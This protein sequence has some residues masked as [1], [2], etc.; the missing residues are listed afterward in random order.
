MNGGVC[1][2]GRADPWLP[3]MD[4]C[5]IPCGPIIWICGADSDVDGGA[6]AGSGRP[7]PP[8]PLTY[9]SADRERLCCG[10]TGLGRLIR[11]GDCDTGDPVGLPSGTP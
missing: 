3:I 9:T 8:P 5:C 10:R 2:S 6:H 11:D 1:G 4:I 7:K